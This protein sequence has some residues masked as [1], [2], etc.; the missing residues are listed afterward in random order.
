MNVLALGF[1]EFSLKRRTQTWLNGMLYS[2]RRYS[3]QISY[4]TKSLS[5]IEVLT[6]KAGSTVKR[7]FRRY[8]TV[9]VSRDL[10]SGPNQCPT[11]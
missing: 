4:R 2:T 1:D 8:K 9:A 3:V 10:S 6:S 11:P 5:A 7:T